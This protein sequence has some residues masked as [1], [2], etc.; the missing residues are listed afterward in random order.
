MLH[1]RDV[2]GADG[3]QLRPNSDGSDGNEARYEAT[4]HENAA[5]VISQPC[6]F[7]RS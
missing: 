7:R 6:Q 4:K 2:I 5:S 3:S 1:L